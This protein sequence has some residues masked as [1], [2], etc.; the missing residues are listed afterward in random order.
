MKNK[1]EIQVYNGKYG[2]IDM[3]TGQ[4]IIPFEYDN[5]F[6][7]HELEKNYIYCE[8]D[9]E[10]ILCKSGKFG[11]VYINSDNSYKWIAPCEYDSIDAFGLYR[12]LIFSK[13]GEKR[14]YFCETKDCKTYLS[15]KHFGQ[16]L[17]SIDNDNYYILRINTGEVLWKCS[18]EK[19]LIQFPCGD[20]CLVYMGDVNELPLF[21]DCCNNGYI[22]PKEKSKLEYQYNIPSTIKPIIVNGINIVNIVDDL[23]GVNVIKHN[24]YD[25]NSKTEYDYDNVTV[26]LKITLKK[27][28]HTEERIFPIP[29]G[30]FSVGDVC[31]LGEW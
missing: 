3:V 11:A 10:Y 4:L 30:K 16:Y 6:R 26:E 13:K 14:Y 28:K 31:D 21:Y 17:F 20:P 9:K 23:H 5:I 22:M 2:I 7:Y 27:G 19:S 15:I 12:D 18:R 29:N 25:E 1:V 24:D 8:L